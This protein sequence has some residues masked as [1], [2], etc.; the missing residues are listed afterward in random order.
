MKTYNIDKKNNDIGVNLD[1]MFY[2]SADQLLPVINQNQN[3][4]MMERRDYIDEEE[5]KRQM[6]LE[7]KKTKKVMRELLQPFV[8]DVKEIEKEHDM[9]KQRPYVLLIHNELAEEEK[10][11]KNT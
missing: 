10:E 6:K 1:E 3:D 8:E 5:E 7:K 9:M 4:G 2:E 11:K